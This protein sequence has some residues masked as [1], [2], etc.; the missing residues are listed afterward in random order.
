MY[1]TFIF[2]VDSNDEGGSSDIQPNP[3]TK[4]GQVRINKN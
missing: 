2:N 4:S 1:E 3:Q